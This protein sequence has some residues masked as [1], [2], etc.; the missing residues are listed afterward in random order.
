MA[1][2]LGHPG[3]FRRALGLACSLPLVLSPFAQQI[4]TDEARSLA[5]L[6]ILIAAVADTQLQS[7]M[8]NNE[9]SGR[10][11]EGGAGVEER[12]LKRSSIYQ[13]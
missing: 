12:M 3:C 8:V 13:P 5:P 9:V 11:T 1:P 10:R 4:I 2:G 6:G 7:F